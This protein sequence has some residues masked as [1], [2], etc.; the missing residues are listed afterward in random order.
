MKCTLTRTAFTL[1]ELLVVIAI[2]A[3]LAGLLLPALAKA[4]EKASRIKCTNNLKQIG[5]GMRMWID[6]HEGHVP[7]DVYRSDGGAKAP[8]A[9]AGNGQPFRARYFVCSNELQS[10]KLLTCPSEDPA[11]GAYRDW[12]NFIAGLDS[13]GKLVKNAPLSYFLCNQVEE[14]F[15]TLLFAG[16][17][18]LG[19]NAGGVFK[20]GDVTYSYG[21]FGQIY[22][23]AIWNPANLHRSAGNVLVADGHADQCSDGAVIKVLQEG[24]NALGGP[25]STANS[26]KIVKNTP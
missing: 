4:K 25:T 16:D 11:A 2:I 7:W 24:L 23:N 13:S 5:L 3:I 9:W 12:P 19:Y 1:I 6:D 17:Q 22:T 14:K 10:P 20:S 21:K 26:T 18:N 8:P 15:P